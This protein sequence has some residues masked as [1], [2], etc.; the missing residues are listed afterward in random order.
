M[1]SD[2]VFR[3]VALKKDKELPCHCKYLDGIFAL[4][5]FQRWLNVNKF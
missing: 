4:E 1:I 5:V 2:K 3:E